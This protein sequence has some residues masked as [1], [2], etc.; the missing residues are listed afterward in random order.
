MCYGDT[1]F[2]LAMPRQ[3]LGN[4]AIAAVAKEEQLERSRA[5]GPHGHTEPVA[6]LTPRHSRHR[7]ERW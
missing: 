7:Q 1:G 4:A 3:G 5:S 2:L 6:V